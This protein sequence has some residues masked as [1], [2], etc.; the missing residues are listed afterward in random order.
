MKARSCFFSLTICGFAL[1]V[2]IS[3]PARAETDIAKKAIAKAEAAMAQVEAACEADLD[4]YCK[5]VTPGEGRIALC[6]MA[7]EDKISDACFDA[8]LR[9][10]DGIDLAVSNLERAA[11]AC[12]GD[13][14]KFCAS[15]EP[16]EGRLVQCLI[17]KKSQLSTQ[18]LGE[19][20]GFEARMQ[21]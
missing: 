3:S 9:V 5:S 15:V 13:I 17:D 18:C 19:V 7:H 12:D 1:A 10:A 4:K 21:K 14:D 2:T 20:A 11:D 6:M 16:G 8:L